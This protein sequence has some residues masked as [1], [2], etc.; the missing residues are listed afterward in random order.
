MTSNALP[1][2]DPRRLAAELRTRAL[3]GCRSMTAITRIRRERA[4]RRVDSTTPDV[5]QRLAARLAATAVAEITRRGGETSIPGGRAAVPLTVA[6]RD[7]RAR[8]VLVRAEGWRYYSRR[9]GSRYAALAYLYGVDDAGPWVVRVP[10]TI[11]TV[12][13]AVAW[14][15]PATV[16]QAQAAGRRVDRQGDV[17][18]VETTAAHDGAGMLPDAHV[19]D[20]TTRTLVHRPADGRAHAPLHLPHRVRFVQQTALPM[21]RGAGRVNG[22]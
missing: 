2:H 20:P 4:A 7:P 11:T 17:Y 13:A 16:G 12:C 1:T 19:W 14:L 8:L 22:D 9:F 21:G 6:D 10:G 15:T 5:T 18:A 3:P